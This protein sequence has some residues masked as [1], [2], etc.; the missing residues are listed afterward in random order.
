MKQSR[1]DSYACTI[2]VAAI[3]LFFSINFA[4]ASQSINTSAKIWKYDSL[5]D[6]PKPINHP[7][8]IIFHKGN[9]SGKGCQDVEKIALHPTAVCVT[10]TNQ[11]DSN[12]KVP[13]DDLKKI[14]LKK[15]KSKPATAIA[16]FAPMA[17]P[18]GSGGMHIFLMEITSKMELV[19]EPGKKA[20]MIF[21]FQSAA[22]GDKVQIGDMSIVTI[23]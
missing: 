5:C 12:I 16:W 6:L 11:S 4:N 14:T 22:P 10:I 3:F 17:N 20:D 23:Q 2:F 9:F 19:I 7:S 15:G 18:L 21:L 1:D 13:V 8:E